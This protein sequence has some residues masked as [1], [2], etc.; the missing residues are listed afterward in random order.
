LREAELELS[1]AENSAEA[2]RNQLAIAERNAALP[3]ENV[4][5]EVEQETELDIRIH[6]LE[7]KLDELQLRYTDQHPDIVAIVP[8]IAQ[9]K[10]RKAA[11]TKRLQEEREARERQ[12][13]GA[14]ASAR[15]RDPVY[16]DLAA[17][18]TTA[19]SNVAVLRTRVAEYRRRYSEL[20]AAAEAVP[21]VEAEFTQLTRDYEVN[22]ARYDELLKRRE[23]AQISGDLEETD[24]VMGFRV[25]DPPRLP[26]APSGTNRKVMMT[27]VLLA[28]IGGG[29]GIAWLVGQMT[30]TVNSERELKELSGQHVLGTVVMAW[31][32]VQK[33]RRKRS[34][35]VFLASFGSLLSAYVGIIAALVLTASRV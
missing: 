11:E 33:K 3:D 31:T 14:S 4:A 6:A 1:E 29:M 30:P 26:L 2:I 12:S 19:E 24:A 17:A 22:K 9:L 7:K 15:V 21:K 10:E 32:D 5:K 23:S 20:Q 16:R 8:M 34:F 13:G 28:A 35:V 25:I 27:L 18:L